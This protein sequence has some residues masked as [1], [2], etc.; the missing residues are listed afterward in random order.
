VQ[1]AKGLVTDH[2]WEWMSIE[3]QYHNDSAA[4]A[5]KTNVWKFSCSLHVKYASSQ[6]EN[7]PG[8]ADFVFPQQVVNFRNK[9]VD[10]L[11]KTLEKGAHD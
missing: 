9:L 11:Q 1:G 8:D 4:T 2:Y 3:V 6:H 7:S 5:A 10:Q